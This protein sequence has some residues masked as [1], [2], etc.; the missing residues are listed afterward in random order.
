MPNKKKP[1][2]VL[3]TNPSKSNPDKEHEI[4]LGGDNKTYCTCWA[5]RMSPAPHKTCLHLKAY[6]ETAREMEKLTRAA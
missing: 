4:R 3:A 2:I 5:W 1:F 6:R